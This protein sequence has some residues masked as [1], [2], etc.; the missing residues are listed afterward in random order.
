MEIFNNFGSLK[1][2]GLERSLKSFFK[3]FEQIKII[4]LSHMI[5]DRKYLPQKNTSRFYM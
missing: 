1:M 4:F 3:D 5:K 2:K